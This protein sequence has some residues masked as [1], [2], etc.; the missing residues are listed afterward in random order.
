MNFSK[1]L[2]LSVTFVLTSVMALAQTINI[3][4]RVIG[5]ADN[6]KIT[7]QNIIGDTISISSVKNNSFSLDIKEGIS[8]YTI[9]IGEYSNTLYIDKN[10]KIGG[11]LDLLNPKSSKISF[12]G[13]E[14]NNVLAQIT[15]E[16]K[17]EISRKKNQLSSIMSDKSQGKDAVNKAQG[18]SSN[19][20]LESTIALKALKT[21]KDPNMAVSLA[22]MYKGKYYDTA[23]ILYDQLSQESRESY[24]GNLLLKFMDSKASLRIG[25]KAPDFEIIDVNGKMRSLKSFKGRIVV[26]DF[27]ASWCG[28]CRSEMVHLR[29][30]YKDLNKKKVE[31]ISICLDDTE[32]LWKAAHEEE[33]I[34]WISLW[35]GAWK[36]SELRATYQFYS[37]PHIIIIDKKGRFQGSGYRRTS[38][39]DKLNELLK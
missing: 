17:N 11:F 1:T 22:F 4:G 32:E 19:E 16:V 37:I 6:N 23:K 34:E 20:F 10:I 29:D 31:F 18:E 7:V 21:I 14:N 39:N 35:A 27:W 28:P 30:V 9:S 13:T 38:L 2:L 15:K 26:L 3:S 36:T 12:K 5:L 33:N 24:T 25:Y 8:L